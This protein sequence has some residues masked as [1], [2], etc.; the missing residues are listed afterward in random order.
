MLAMHLL[1]T[2]AYPELGKNIWIL[3]LVVVPEALPDQGNVC[4]W[5]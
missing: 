5:A 3:F 4:V 2:L 1:H